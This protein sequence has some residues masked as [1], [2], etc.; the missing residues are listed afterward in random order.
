[1]KSQAINYAVNKGRFWT[2][3]ASQMA[4]YSVYGALLLTRARRAHVSKPE[5]H[6]YRE[7]DR[8][9]TVC[10]CNFIC[11]WQNINIS[12]EGDRGTASV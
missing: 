11:H 12:V 10:R 6:T 5:I 8:D 4:P 2:V 7:I 1:M 3:S 9:L